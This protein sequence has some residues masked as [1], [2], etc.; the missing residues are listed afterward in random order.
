MAGFSTT[1]MRHVGMN[2][3]AIKEA[4][5]S[6]LIIGQQYLIISDKE[7]LEDKRKRDFVRYNLVSLGR[8]TVVF[9]YKNGQ[10]ETSSC[11]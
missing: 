1:S 2:R 8:N 3:V 6:K 11:K 4:I 9:E 5:K 10:K 7:P